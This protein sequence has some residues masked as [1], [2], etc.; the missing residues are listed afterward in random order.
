MKQITTIIIAKNEKDVIA[1][2]IASVKDI[3]EE[4]VVVI[5][6]SADNTKEVAE[7]KGARILLHPFTDFSDQRN[8]AMLHAK[9][10]W[11]LYLDAD[12]RLTES[13]KK[14]VEKVIEEYD[15]RGSVGGYYINR[16]TY[17]FGKDWGLTDKVQRLFY[18][19]KFIEWYGAVHETP[20]IHGEFSEI[21]HPILHFTHRN[22]SQMVEKTNEWSEYE[23]GLRLQAN[24]PHMTSWRFVRVMATEFI[25]SYVKNKG[26]KNG[27]YG[28]IEAIYQAYSM[29]IT[30]A[31]LWEM[32]QGKK[33]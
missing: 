12:E 4:I 28:I 9:T 22:L 14:E 29:F 27:T 3:S 1:D 8:Y 13:F 16:K 7:K 31:K 30:Y 11:V 26:Y 18:R 19:E 23:A 15:E 6:N 24:H 25:N 5:G 10:P 33:R 20:K 21:K 2:A 17:Y 32:Q